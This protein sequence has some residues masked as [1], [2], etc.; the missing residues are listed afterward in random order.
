MTG[1]INF[2]EGLIADDDMRLLET[3]HAILRKLR[4]RFSK[5]E[6][7]KKDARSLA[8]EDLQGRSHQ[9]VIV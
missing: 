1:R 9:N 3:K 7:N 5:L 8:S 2:D 6:H 4:M